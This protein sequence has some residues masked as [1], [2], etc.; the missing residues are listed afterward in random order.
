MDAPFDDARLKHQFRTADRLGAR[1]AVVI[2]ERELAAG[3][4][5][6]R[7]LSDGEERDVPFE[8]AIAWMRQGRS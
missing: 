6:V 7:R 5:T 8:D 4:V 3:T 1:F 2:G